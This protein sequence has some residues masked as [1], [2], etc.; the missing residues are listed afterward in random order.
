[1]YVGTAITVGIIFAVA[2]TIA[3]FLLVIPAKK[4]G[5]LNKF[6]QFLHDTFTFKT[7]I[8]E[9][10]LQV[11]Y[12]LSTC[13]TV[14]IGFFFLFA[15]MGYWYYSASTAL[16][17]LGL[18]ILGPIVARIVYEL[19]MLGVLQ[20]KNTIEINRKL[21]AFPQVREFMGASRRPVTPLHTPEGPRTGAA[22]PSQ[23]VRREPAQPQEEPVPPAEPAAQPEPKPA[24][25]DPE[26][27]ESEQAA[28][29]P[30]QSSGGLVHCDT[31]GTW[32]QSK[33]GACPICGAKGPA[34][35]K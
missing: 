10:I 23:P 28:P 9:K 4:N 1:M 22:A 26:V 18:M 32:Y 13:L 3:L 11:L 35:P 8:I 6:L 16:Y 25:S 24:P 33:A 34:E 27:P 2:A 31:C 19:L 29:A 5:Q 21:S 14:F 7:L 12:V 20:V 30:V 15:R 17:G